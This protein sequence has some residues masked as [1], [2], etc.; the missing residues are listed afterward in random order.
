LWLVLSALW[1][2][3]SDVS[4]LGLGPG[5]LSSIK[6]VLLLVL[7]DGLSFGVL[8]LGIGNI[9]IVLWSLPPSVPLAA[10]ALDFVGCFTA[11]SSKHNHW[12][13]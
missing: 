6:V 12:R 9:F 8:V 11:G 4:R 7:L 2:C 1:G 10:V 13:K 3:V 5:W